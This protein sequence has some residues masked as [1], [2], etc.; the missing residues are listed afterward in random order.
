[1]SFKIKIQNTLNFVLDINLSQEEQN[2][3]FAEYKRIGRKY[4][5]WG[6]IFA[7]IGGPSILLSEMNNGFENKELW[8]FYRLLPSV[9]ILIGFLLF[10]YLKLSHEFLF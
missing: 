3:W 1:M 5:T 7:I 9:T 6:A 8:L 10:K 4:A 2:R